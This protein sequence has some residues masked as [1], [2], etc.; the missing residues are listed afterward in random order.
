M[1]H[2][3]A[4]GVAAHD[5]V[6]HDHQSLAADHVGQRV[7]L[8]AQAVAAKLLS[9]LDERARHVAVLDQAVV[10]GDP[11]GAGEALRGGVAGVGDRDHQVRVDRRLAGEDL[12][13]PAADG[14]QRAPSSLESGREK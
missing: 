6:V 7:E 3:L 14:L 11:G 4:H 2:D 10:L 8:H 12:A 13:H 5:R 9:G 1:L